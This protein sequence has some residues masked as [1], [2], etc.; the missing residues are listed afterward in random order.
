MICCFRM[1]SEDL[2]MM[3]NR[4][5]MAAC[6]TITARYDREIPRYLPRKKPG[7][8]NQPYLFVT[9]LSRQVSQYS[10]VHGLQC[11]VF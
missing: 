11:P 8:F 7:I 10:Y 4:M 9:Q 1:M 3:S 5:M 6:R 2:L